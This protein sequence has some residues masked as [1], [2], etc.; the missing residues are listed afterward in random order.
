MKLLLIGSVLT[1][2]LVACAEGSPVRPDGAAAE[3]WQL[4]SG[5]V[6]GERVPL[7]PGYRI[8]LTIEGNSVTGTRRATGMEAP[9][10]FAVTPSPWKRSAQPKWVAGMT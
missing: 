4:E 10:A 5:T 2:G 1:L 9:S 7:V 3:S 6:G 8:T